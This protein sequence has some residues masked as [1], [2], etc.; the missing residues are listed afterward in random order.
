MVFVLGA[1]PTFVFAVVGGDLLHDDW[2]VT[3]A[4][5]TEPL[6]D[7]V[8]RFGWDRP[9]RPGSAVW[10]G[11][12]YGTFGDHPFVHLVLLAALNG[13]V[14][15][16]VFVVAR[17][18]FGAVPGSWITAVW[19]VLPNRSSDRFW[20]VIAP[21]VLAVALLLVGLWLLLDDHALPAGIVLGLGVVTYEGIVGLAVLALAWFAFT[22]R[23]RLAKVALAAVPV[24]LAAAV[25]YLRSPKRRYGEQLQRDYSASDLVLPSQFGAGLV[26]DRLASL[27][28]LVVCLAVAWSV[29]VIAFPSFRERRRRWNDLVLWGA[30]MVVVSAAPFVVGQFP[31][32]TDGIFDRGNV[33]VGLGTSVLLGG[34]LVGAADAL[35]EVPGLVLGAVVLVP[36]ALLNVPDLVSFRDANR[37]ADAI[38]ARMRTDVPPST[39]PIVV[40]PEL[41]PH[42]GVQS[43]IDDSNLRDALV[44]RADWSP[45]TDLR[46]EPCPDTPTVAT[47]DWV[48]REFRRPEGGK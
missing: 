3:K 12:T 1:L 20:I 14:A 2:W 5:V 22:H 35:G 6:W 7:V 4:Y 44:L 10:Y 34:L 45:H 48:T 28:I 23:D 19:L 13:I 32:A 46:I 47:Y 27:S 9:A 40:C 25:T 42:R 11:L 21:Y 37:D 39:S 18:L 31:L 33:V 29:V 16:L 41:T 17:R 26:G 43:F 8:Y 30:V 38:V 24:V 15:V 36:L